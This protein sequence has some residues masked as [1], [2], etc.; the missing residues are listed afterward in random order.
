M[1]PAQ[2]DHL[3]GISSHWY[4]RLLLHGTPS[5][6][7]ID[8]YDFISSDDVEFNKD[9][10]TTARFVCQA[11]RAQVPR[12]RLKPRTRMATRRFMAH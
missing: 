3:H 12:H 5:S 2:D 1:D 6:Q 8:M 4:L 7:V 9:W 11:E 10:H